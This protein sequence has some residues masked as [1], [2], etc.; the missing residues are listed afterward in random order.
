VAPASLSKGTVGVD[1]VHPVMIRA[2]DRCWDS[3]LRR[4]LGAVYSLVSVMNLPHVCVVYTG[5]W[6]CCRG[7]IV[8]PHQVYFIEPL[9]SRHNI[10]QVSFALSYT[11]L[12]CLLQTNT[13]DFS[14][15][16]ATWDQCF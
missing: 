7:V 12:T 2:P 6:W 5:W 14:S 8:L 9:S 3:S 1:L 16:V 13:R 15:L 4:W 10:S 11:T